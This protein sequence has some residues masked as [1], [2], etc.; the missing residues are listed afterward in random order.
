MSKE[1]QSA[2]NSGWQKRRPQ[3]FRPRWVWVTAIA[4]VVTGMG[5][6]AAPKLK[7]A[8][9]RRS[10]ASAVKRATEALAKDDIEQAM[11]NA[12]VALDGNPFDVEA[13]RIVAQ[14]LEK[15]GSPAALEWRRR[16]GSIRPDDTENLI[17][18]S[19]DSLTAGYPDT[20]ADVL[21]RVKPED[22]NSAE[23]HDVAAR[24]AITRQDE[25]GAESHWKEAARL[26][27]K[28][29]RYRLNL[30]VM[31]RKNGEGTAREE[32]LD[33]LRQLAADPDSGRAA[34][35]A[36]LA[37]AVARGD[38]DRV[39]EMAEA[40]ASGPGAT[41][42]DRL[43][44]L[45]ALRSMKDPDSSNVMVEL[46]DG[47]VAKP[48]ELFQLLSWMNAHDLALLLLDIVNAD[49][50]W[51]D[52]SSASLIEAR[53]DGSLAVNAIICAELAPAFDFDWPQLDEWLTRSR[54]LREPLLFPA[55]TV[56]AAAHREYRRRGGPRTSPLPDFFIGARAEVSGTTLL[57]R[58]AT[59]YRTCF[60]Q[61]PLV[62]PA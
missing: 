9:E 58:D 28:M 55:T 12:R 7:R 19:R 54:I 44:R 20:A 49:R 22:R 36:I 17:A 59:R 14:V 8:Y 29:E 33:M 41:F 42:M 23:Y 1:S 50:L 4:A 6:F 24:L 34:Q 46:R 62:C 60:P 25:A 47:A 57:T 26:D 40:I 45:S 3:W 35:R 31:Q 18:W 56:A 30:A 51:L 27:P 52:W 5:I 2:E 37:D 53:G 43:T 13:N 38:G 11:L 10:G 61:V 16:L 15:G 39:K 48:E 21:G 32:A